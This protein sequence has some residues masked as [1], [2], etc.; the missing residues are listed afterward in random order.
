MK[1]HLHPDRDAVGYCVACGKGVCAE[2]RREVAG[3][4]R[5]PEHATTIAAPLMPRQEKSSFLAGLFS[6]L[7]GLGHIYLGAYS[8][9][10]FIGL[11]FALLI[12]VESHG[13]GGFE[14]LFG[15]GIA[16]VWFFGLFDALRICNAINS[17]AAIDSF[18][19]G[20]ISAPM[21]PKPRSRAGNLTW[22]VI[23]VGLGGLMVADRYVDLDR[24]FD[25]VG[26]NIGFI[27]ILLG[28]LLIAGYMRRESHKKA[29]AEAAAHPT[30]SSESGIPRI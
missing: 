26:D 10:L 19:G 1:C 7:P 29:E 5:C 20:A 12:G 9:G 18:A 4:I 14:P 15:I 16:F 8:R 11:M 6:F 23:L 21:I 27:F 25:F 22:G 28:I 17:G 30:E 13:A 3:T 24:F 2:C